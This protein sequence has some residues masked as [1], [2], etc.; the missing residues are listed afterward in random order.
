MLCKYR[1]DDLRNTTVQSMSSRSYTTRFSYM[2]SEIAGQL[3]FCV[4]SFYLLKFYTDVYGISA[5]VAGMIL[6]IAR[7]VDAFDAPLWG[8]LFEK[9]HSRWG[10]SRPWFLWLCLPFAVF[11]VLTFVTP[12]FGPASKIIYAVLTYVAS[13]ILY[14]GINTPVTSILASLTSDPHERITL[15]TWRMFGSKLSVLF[16]NLSV[17]PL[18]SV[19][20]Q[21]NDR[22][23]FM[24]VMPIYALG[25]VALYLVAFRNLHEA[26]P[27]HRHRLPVAR[28]LHALRGNAPWH[29]IFFSSLFF[30]IAFIARISSAPY[31]FQYVLRRPELTSIANSMDVVSLAGIFFLPTLCRCFSKR[32]T[33]VVALLGSIAGQVILGAGTF[34]ASIPLIFAGWILG[35]LASGIAMAIP[36][37]V[38]SDSVDYGEWKSGIRAAGL[39]TAIGAAFCLKAGSGIGGA[40]SAWILANTGY[41]PN[42]IQSSSALHG[43]C[44]SFIWLPAAAWLLATV[45]VC[46][47]HRYECLEPRIRAELEARRRIAALVSGAV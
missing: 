4:I 26:V 32:N 7:C 11:G 38:L 17:L 14:T 22:L 39:L 29:I 21:G 30:W 6:L 3:I 10:S 19:L 15:T 42:A 1:E 2:A 9:T 35:F 5:A 45:P 25:T 33:W 18:V 36:F 24:R 27:T 28:S 40:A 23:G 47:Y 44:A 16:V 46:F 34:A 13:S 37:S 12:H 20:G 31:F 43:I 8:I 41:V